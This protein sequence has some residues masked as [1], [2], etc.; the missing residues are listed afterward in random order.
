MRESW[1]Y[2]AE[3]GV[4]ARIDRADRAS[5]HTHHSPGTSRE[6]R[7]AAEKT[8]S[9]APATGPTGTGGNRAL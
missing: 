4:R 9:V 3:S 6:A 2:D 5:I 8:W 1:N 7:R